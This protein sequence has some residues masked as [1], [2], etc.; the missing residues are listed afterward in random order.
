[1]FAGSVRRA[2]AVNDQVELGLL[3][4]QQPHLIV[5]RRNDQVELG[6]LARNRLLQGLDLGRRAAPAL[7]IKCGRNGHR[8]LTVSESGALDQHDGGPPR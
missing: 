2:P 6:L 3:A 7:L 4:R 8:T 5:C 1:M